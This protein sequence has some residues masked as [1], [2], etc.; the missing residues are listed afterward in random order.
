MPLD[1][2]CVSGQ[3]LLM[4]EQMSLQF[5]PH[6]VVAFLLLEVHCVP[7]STGMSVCCF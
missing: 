1:I 5:L 3:H 7:H 6:K 2:V 4:R